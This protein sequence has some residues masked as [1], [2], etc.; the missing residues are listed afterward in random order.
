MPKEKALTRM[1]TPSRLPRAIRW[2]TERCGRL[3]ELP[4]GCSCALWGDSVAIALRIG[5]DGPFTMLYVGVLR[6]RRNLTDET[7]SFFL[8]EW[9]SNQKALIDL[10]MVMDPTDV[11][12]YTHHSCDSS[13]VMFTCG[14]AGR[15][16]P[17]QPP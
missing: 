10:L 5:R 1:L 13:Q 8:I 11:I 2:G 6:S 16:R 9:N 14:W 12:M 3:Y 15:E 7:G 17:W 4:K